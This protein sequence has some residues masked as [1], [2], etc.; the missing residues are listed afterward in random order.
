MGKDFDLL[1]NGSRELAGRIGNDTGV[2]Y[3]F[4]LMIDCY[5]VRQISMNGKA[6]DIFSSYATAGLRVVRVSD[7]RIVYSLAVE[8]VRGQGNDT[9]S[10][11]RDVF[12][13]S[14][15]ELSSALK[16][17]LSELGTAIKSSSEGSEPSAAIISS[18]ECVIRRESVP[19]F[20][21][22]RHVSARS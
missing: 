5:D 3:L 14:R 4:I 2:S 9:E 6:Y 19:G 8:K 11:V 10:S 21:S 13:K 18:R 20:P 22:R 15:Q 16:M 12:A 17:K 7:G 1:Y